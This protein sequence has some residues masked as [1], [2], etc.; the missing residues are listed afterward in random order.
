M[1]FEG[2]GIRSVSPVAVEKRKSPVR[3]SPGKRSL[4][5][6]ELPSGDQLMVGKYILGSPVDLSIFSGPP[7]AGTLYN[8]LSE[9]EMRW[10]AIWVPS[11]DHAALIHADGW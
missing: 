3:S 8:P 9:P 10:N 4:N 7:S 2:F 1:Q 6:I 5:A 11:G